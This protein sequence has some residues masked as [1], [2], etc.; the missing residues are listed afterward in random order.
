MVAP[1]AGTLERLL[2]AGRGS[3]KVVTLAP[4]LPGALDLIPR[5]L[6]GGAIPAI[7][8]TDA[9]YEQATAAID[10]G[11]RIATHLF[12]GMRPLHHRDPGVVIASIERPEVTCELIGDGFHVHPAAVAHVVRAAGP[13]RVALI[14]DAIAAAGMPDG[15]YALG[16]MAVEVRGAVARLAGGGS[17]AGSTLTMAGALRRA[18]SEMALTVE[19]AVTVVAGTPARVL[20]LERRA[21]ALVAGADQARAIGAD[22]G[23]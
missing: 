15:R 22:R 19:E 17:I 4:E 10:A 14:T 5:I 23:S 9:T 8:H 20:G 13:R 1:D 7:G 21:G 11:A 16:S 6:D 12:N 2:Q 18:V 3:V